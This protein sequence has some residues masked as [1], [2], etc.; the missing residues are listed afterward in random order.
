LT[1][2]ASP[3]AADRPVFHFTVPLSAEEFLILTGLGS[4]AAE[5]R[6]HQHTGGWA[7]VDAYGGVWGWHPVDDDDAN[8]SDAAAALAAFIIDLDIRARL[9]SDGFRVVADDGARLHLLL[10]SEPWYKLPP[11]PSGPTRRPNEPILPHWGALLDAALAAVS[12]HGGAPEVGVAIEELIRAQH[13][14]F[15]RPAVFDPTVM[16]RWLASDDAPAA[17]TAMRV[18]AGWASG[19]SSYADAVGL[20]D[21]VGCTGR[22]GAQHTLDA[23]LS[24]GDWSIGTCRACWH[25]LLMH[26]S[27]DSAEPF[28]VWPV[29]GDLR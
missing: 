1:A 28:T 18:T 25:P 11:A 14:D 6:T 16:R 29:F 21:P 13:S 3:V 5:R 20:L 7:L 23:H 22:R 15:H 26:E 27:P 10:K 19:P 17:V 8:W 2:F 4:S 24:D 9:V 12:Q